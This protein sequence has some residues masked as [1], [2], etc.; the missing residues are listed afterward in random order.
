MIAL[1]RSTGHCTAA[2]GFAD[3]RGAG[4]AYHSRFPDRERRLEADLASER[5]CR[6]LGGDLDFLRDFDLG[7][8]TFF[9][10]A[11]PDDSERLLLKL[12]CLFEGDCD[13]FFLET[14]PF[15]EADRC[16]LFAVPDWLLERVR[17]L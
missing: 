7:I 3:V 16:F 12:E 4:W 1:F 14:C 15:R 8:R 9:L 11:D 10:F 2:G 5:D 17:R 13:R 6:R